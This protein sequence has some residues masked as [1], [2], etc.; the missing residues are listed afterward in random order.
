M[1]TSH[2]QVK[3]ADDCIGDAVANAV[4][5]L[6]EGEV[7]L[8]ENLLF[9]AGETTNDAGFAQQLAAN[10]DLYVNE[11]LRLASSEHAST[12]AITR[13][14]KSVAGLALAKEL[15]YLVKAISEP[16]RPMMA[17]VGGS[18][19]SSKS[20]L[21]ES[22]LDKCDVILLGGG[23]IFTL[24]K[25]QGLSIGSSNCEESQIGLAASFLEK[26]NAKGVQVVL[27]TDVNIADKFDAHAN[28]QMVSIKAIQDGWMG[29]DLGDDT[30]RSYDQKLSDAK[31]I[32]WNGTMGVNEFPKF[33]AGTNAIIS[34]LAEM[35][36]RGATTIVLG[37]DTVAAVEQA[38][39]ANKLTHVSTGDTAG[40]DLVEGKVLPG[41][42]ALHD[43]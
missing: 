18:K 32:F 16:Q 17:L 15:D 4:A 20:T 5:S 29:L 14:S 24:Y 40:L 42:A 30:I 11:A 31:S 27:P 6:A 34:K 21:L 7:L 2:V 10:A 37:R 1:C 8:L 23:L 38:G 41:V 35:T 13:Y 12:V 22:L 36:E 26:A 9:H 25:A 39:F 3:K 19:L 43:Q 28:T 33:A